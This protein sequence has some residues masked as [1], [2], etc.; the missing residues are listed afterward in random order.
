M[1][2]IDAAPPPPPSSS[3]HSS[4]YPGPPNLPPG[5]PSFFSMPAPYGAQP[6]GLPSFTGYGHHHHGLMNSLRMPHYSMSGLR[7]KKEIKRRTKTGCM[8]CRQRRIKAIGP[9][10]GEKHRVT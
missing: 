10:C 5:P 3:M 9:N 4:S 8:T 2:T 7:H 1:R 6:H